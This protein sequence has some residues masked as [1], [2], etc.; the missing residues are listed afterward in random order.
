MQFLLTEQER[1]ALVD[2]QEL[3]KANGAI[4]HMRRMIVPDGKCIHDAD[5]PEY[6]DRCPLSSPGIR[7]TSP[8][9]ELSQSMCWLNRN[10]SK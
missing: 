8:S 4:A 6:C 7:G 3:H 5:G 2:A 9:Y 10:Y 1:A